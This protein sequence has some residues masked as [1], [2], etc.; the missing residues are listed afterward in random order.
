MLRLR[1]DL[2]TAGQEYVTV[3][4]NG[5]AVPGATQCSTA[6]D[7]GGA[8]GM[9]SGDPGA[10]DTCLAAADVTAL[11]AGASA[12]VVVTLQASSAVNFCSPMMAADIWC[13]S[14]LAVH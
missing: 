14:R 6:A 3:S 11:V 2:A 4:V 7:C 12:T 10:G 8:L 5:A 13:V 1:G 9:G